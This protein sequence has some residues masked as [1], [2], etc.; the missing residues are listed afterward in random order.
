MSGFWTGG[1]EEYVNAIRA[2]Y[3]TRIEQLRAK[4][5]QCDDSMRESIEIQIGE[6]ERELKAK[7]DNA[8]QSLF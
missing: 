4:L 6:L 3:Q 7:I 1:H 2:E 5:Q 8:D